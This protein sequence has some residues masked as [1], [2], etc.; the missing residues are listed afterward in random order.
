[1]SLSPKNLIE[2]Q[3]LF[4]KISDS[5]RWGSSFEVESKS[6]SDMLGPIWF[7]FLTNKSDQIN[8]LQKTLSATYVKEYILLLSN[9]LTGWVRFN[10]Q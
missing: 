3:I 5:L 6:S 10:D 1:M 2:S 4:D 7:G 8:F 9:K